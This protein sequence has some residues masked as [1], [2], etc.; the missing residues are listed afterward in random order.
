MR[1]PVGARFVVFDVA[2]HEGHQGL[3]LE[4]ARVCEVGGVS[5]LTG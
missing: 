3:G 5:M 4:G 1:I 2:E